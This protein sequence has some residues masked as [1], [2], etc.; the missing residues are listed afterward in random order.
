MTDQPQQPEPKPGYGSPQRPMS[1]QDEKTW[2]TLVHLSPFASAVV[3]MP[4]LGP[5]VIYLV[6]R[7]RGP[8]IRHHTAQ[9][10][11]FQLVLLVAYVGLGL[12]SLPIVTLIITVPLLIAV[13]IASVVFQIIAAVKAN[14]GEWY[15]YPMTPDWV[16]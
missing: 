2:A 5:L 10:L 9:A 7:D 11:N 4:F 12:L 6:L 8:F 3:G 16:K 14:N 13:A 1:P 15:R